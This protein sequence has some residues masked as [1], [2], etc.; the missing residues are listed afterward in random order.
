MYMHVY[1]DFHTDSGRADLDSDETIRKEEY[2]KLKFVNVIL[3]DFSYRKDK[4]DI[5]KF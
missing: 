3:Y 1:N 5:T 4:Y 2:S